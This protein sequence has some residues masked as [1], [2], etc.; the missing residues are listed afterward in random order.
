MAT[1]EA[2]IRRLRRLIDDTGHGYSQS[3]P[4]F[5]INLTAS[6]ASPL[7]LAVELD[8]DLTPTEIT[9]GVAAALGTGQA[10]AS[11]LQQAIRAADP[12]LL[13]PTPV[14][15]TAY[16]NISVSFDRVEGY[17]IRSGSIGAQSH[18]RILPPTTAP[19]IDASALLKLGQT[20]GGYESSARVNFTDDEL[21]QLLDEALALQ[22]AQ[23]SATFWTYDTIPSAYET[24]VVYR[25]WASVIDVKMGENANNYWQKVESE[26]SHEELIFSNFLKLADWLKKRI[27]EI[28][29]DLD[30]NIIVS[31][32][33]RWSYQMQEMIPVSTSKDP[34]IVA[35]IVSVAWV[36][37]TSALVEF[38]EILATTFDEINVGYR[39]TNP[40]VID[41]SIYNDANY[42]RDYA[43]TKGFVSPSVLSRTLRN[44][45]NTLVKIT[46][47]DRTLTTYFA[48]MAVDANGVRYFSNEYRLGGVP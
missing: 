25:A 28:E 36:D 11:A 44:G 18:V 30:G 45:R 24:L 31:N 4:G 8:N 20:S 6:V 39:V 48:V 43:K 38:S 35:A 12:G 14:P 9:V 15:T 21:A 5:S 23:G 10:I 47:L 19:F 42:A 22:N 13:L 32:V 46:G 17:I 1:Q 16:A 41:R 33:S 3:A 34:S 37:A 27:E 40:G 7:K 29:G 2:L 26:E